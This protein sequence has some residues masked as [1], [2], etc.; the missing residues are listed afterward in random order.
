[1]AKKE[2]Y[3][4]L[5]DLQSDDLNLEKVIEK[6]REEAKEEEIPERLKP[7]HLDEI[8]NSQKKKGRWD[9]MKKRKYMVAAAWV[10]VLVGI[11]VS[12]VALT[13][14][15]DSA[16]IG[17]QT[18]SSAKDGSGNGT[19][20]QEASAEEKQ[21]EGYK[22]A[23][24]YEEI[25]QKLFV[26]TKQAQETQEAWYSSSSNMDEDYGIMKESA[27]ADG[28]ASS[29]ARAVSEDNS[30]DSYSRTNVRTEG[31]DEGDL[32]KTDGTYIYTLT[33]SGRL[34]ITKAEGSKLEK[35]GETSLESMT[36][37]ISD[38]YVDGNTVCIV[39]YG[40][41]TD[42][43]MEGE[44]TYAVNS[45]NYTKLYTYDVSDKSNIV[46]KGTIKQEGYYETS[47][48]VGNYMYLFSTYY[49][50]E[51]NAS[52]DH[53]ELLVPKINGV[54]IQASDVFCP[55]EPQ[56][57]TTQL[58]ISSV[59]LE[60]PDKVM[61]SRS[62]IGAGGMYYVSQNNIY[63]CMSQYQTQEITTQ[64]ARF[65]YADGALELKAAG[66]INGTIHDSFCLDENNGCLRAVVTRYPNG[67]GGQESN[68]LYVLDENM[69]V[70]GKIEDL[71]FGESIQSA[72]FLGDTG[73]FV[74]YKQ[75]DPLFSVDLKDP[76]NPKVI[77]ELKV[78]GFSEYLHFYG[79]NKLLGIG[80]ETDPDTGELKGIK[81]SMF[82][83]SN[84]ADVKEVDKIVLKDID[85]YSPQDNY[86]SVMIDADEN[87]IGFAMGSYDKVT[88]NLK[89]YYGVFGYSAE[90]GFTQDL[91][92]SLS[93]ATGN[94][95]DSYDVIDETRGIYIG[96]T[97]YL[98][99][100]QGI[101]AFDRSD[102]YKEI[103]KLEW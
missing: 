35:A 79:E 4:N 64:I 47:R 102:G 22:A 95:S 43:S 7:E 87:I 100:N 38:M 17:A 40:Y 28:T 49:A 55:V 42:V 61:A 32:V 18:A 2:E 80:K 53:P 37:T 8:L 3:H 83:I 26:E 44:D 46:L 6:I 90:D 12:G 27:V 31:V 48:K 68:G 58:V 25:Y 91:M 99:Q 94:S 10:A 14:K 103:G 21:V 96:D 20:S 77:G 69:K 72:R 93:K 50:Q 19:L 73:Y 76:E 88:Y 52:D 98:C 16:E 1:M 34:M 15:K 9:E 30:S 67:W 81:L 82:D 13:H 5:K 66:Q 57:D 39:A 86:K 65:S 62:L 24:S 78:T 71:A 70:S 33:R 23:S 84:P 97:F 11:G 85:V 51:E 60:E 101:Y 45:T 41:D 56:T 63:V 36:D 89:G 74:T 92:Q 29:M 59:N 75:V 54:P